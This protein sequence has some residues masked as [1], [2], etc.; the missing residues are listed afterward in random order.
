MGQ[1]LNFQHNMTNFGSGDQGTN[2]AVLVVIMDEGGQHIRISAVFTY[3]WCE[4]LFVAKH[5]LSLANMT[6]NS[7]ISINMDER[8]YQENLVLIHYIPYFYIFII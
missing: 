4:S 3:L 6:W 2:L 8:W 5:S 1:P 7:S